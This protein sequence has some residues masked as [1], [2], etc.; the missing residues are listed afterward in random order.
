MKLFV[1]KIITSYACKKWPCYGSVHT[2]E[3]RLKFPYNQLF[4]SSIKLRWEYTLDFLSQPQSH[5]M[6]ELAP[7]LLTFIALGNASSHRSWK[8][9]ENP[10]TFPSGIISIF[11]MLFRRK[12]YS[13]SNQPEILI[14]VSLCGS[15]IT[16]HVYD[17]SLSI[18]SC[19]FLNI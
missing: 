18:I 16:Y 19:Y 9:G 2:Q 7:K 8:G 12:L 17:C 15:L 5:C 4:S 13:V 6:A 10:Q 1:L 14:L 3:A 11:L